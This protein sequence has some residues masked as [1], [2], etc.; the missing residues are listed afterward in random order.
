MHSLPKFNLRYSVNQAASISQTINPAAK[1]DFDDDVNKMRFLSEQ[2]VRC[3]DDETT[4]TNITEHV[5]Q[6]ER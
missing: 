6:M 2:S 4:N 5:K 1:T 3:P